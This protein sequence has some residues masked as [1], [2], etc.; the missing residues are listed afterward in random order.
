MMCS[1]KMRQVFRCI[2]LVLALVSTAPFY[3]GSLY[4]KERSSDSTALV[5]QALQA[6]LDGDSERRGELL[7]LALQRNPDDSAARWLSGYVRHDNQWMLTSRSAFLNAIDETIEQ[8]EELRERF[9][10]S[11]AGEISLARWCRR[12]DLED[13][14]FMHWRNVIETDR[15]NEEARKRLKLVNLRG[16]LIDKAEISAKK[17]VYKDYHRGLRVWGPKLNRLRHGIKRTGY[18]VDSDAWR[19]LSEIDDPEA[20][21]AMVKMVPVVEQKLQCHLIRTIANIPSQVSAN[22]LVQLS[23]NLTDS[24]ARQ[25][26]VEGLAGHPVHSYAP[27]YLNLLESPVEYV[28][29]VKQVGDLVVSHTQMRN[30]RPDDAINVNQFKEARLRFFDSENEELDASDSADFDPVAH[31]RAVAEELR[32]Q[33][34]KV[35]DTERN[36]DRRNERINLANGRIFKALRMT[37]GEE[38]GNEPRQWWDW[39]KKYNEYLLAEGKPEYYFTNTE[40]RE[41]IERLPPPRPRCE[42][43]PAGTLVHTETGKRA[44]ETIRRGDKVLSQD[45]A[46]GELSYQ[47]VTRTTLRPPSATTRMTIAGEE[48]TS[49]TGHPFW[50]IGKGWTMAKHLSVGDRLQCIGESNPIDAIENVDSVE[51]HNLIVDQTNAYFVGETGVLV[52]DNVL[53]SALRIPIP[54]WQTQ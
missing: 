37:T 6:D 5:Q 41:R 2:V 44:I 14:E 27:R 36:I 4:G 53:R 29:T 15:T 50:V 32:L 54:G 16:R 18:C 1:L 31:R 22:A 45:P 33:Q 52:H 24:V 21:P 38:I 42:C 47:V 26:A 39:W 23:I 51:A 11:L 20:I 49:T 7:E 19:E 35:K 9:E 13:R 12:H 43:F 17:A 34:E 3:W 8:Y 10:G 48:I 46:T 40:Y 28:S 25:A 30:E